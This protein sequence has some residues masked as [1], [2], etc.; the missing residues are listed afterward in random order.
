MG[1]QATIPAT[2]MSSR[3][4]FAGMQFDPERGLEQSGRLIPLAPLERRALAALLAADGKVVSK[5]ALILAVWHSTAVSD[6]C[7]SRTVYRLRCALRA[8]GAG[9]VL[10]TVYG[11]GFRIGV[12]I[13]QAGEREGSPPAAARECATTARELIGRRSL[14]DMISATLAARR[15]VQIDPAFIEAWVLLAQISVLRVNRGQIAPQ[16]GLRRAR[17]AV[18]QALAVSPEA[19][20]ALAL[21]GWMTAVIDGETSAGLALID[22]ALALNDT[23]WIT[24]ML[25]AWALHA[26]HR[27]EVGLA[28][29]KAMMRANPLSTF[30]T[31]NYGYA[32]GCSGRIE[33]AFALLNRAI[34]VMPTVDSLF[35]ARSSVAAM[36]GDLDGALIDARRCAELSPDVPNQLYALAYAL[37][38]TGAVDEARQTLARMLRARCRLAPSWHALVLVGL[39]DH[40]AATQILERAEQER[41]SWLSF[42]QY[43]PRLRGVARAKSRAMAPSAC[44]SRTLVDL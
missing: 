14:Q 36:A 23:D 41:C 18:R 33:E 27:P 20:G 10:A 4:H 2:P 25:R 24:H 40:T 12:P 5:D 39:K 34:R 43:D 3:Y 42:V 6:A 31:G 28:A 17:W 38:A 1:A 16:A 26:A 8:A 15:A 13:T 19:D 32:L 11:V 35:S 30:S 7:I 37:A 9:K 44:P 29:F 21:L 22:R